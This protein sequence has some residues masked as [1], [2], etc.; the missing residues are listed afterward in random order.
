[1]FVFAFLSFSIDLVDL[2]TAPVTAVRRCVV[3]MALL[4]LPDL[5]L[6]F[7]PLPPLAEC[8]LLCAFRAA[9]SFSPFGAGVSVWNLLAAPL[10]CPRAR[11]F[12]RPAVHPGLVG[13]LVQFC[14]D[15]SQADQRPS[16][17]L[18]ISDNGLWLRQGDA[19]GQSVIHA[20]RVA[21]Q[22]V[23]AEDVTI[24]STAQSTASKAHRCTICGTRQRAW[25]LK[26]AW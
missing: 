8:L 21:D 10:S 15:G 13:L 25:T 7:S 18:A 2:S 19:N 22:G 12:R 5:A 4:Q 16:S 24:F 6:N 20:Q 14:V 11:D 1:M 26:N 3:A 17:Q 9:T 23:H